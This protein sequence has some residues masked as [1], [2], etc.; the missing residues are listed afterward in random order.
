MEI[1]VMRRLP[2]FLF[3]VGL[4]IIV[5]ILNILLKV[6]CQ[7]NNG[8]TPVIISVVTVSRLDFFHR[9]WC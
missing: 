1:N 7:K 3:K 8:T 9:V 4:V 2:D 6:M 5:D